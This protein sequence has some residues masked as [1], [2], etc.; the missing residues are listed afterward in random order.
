MKKVIGQWRRR[1]TSANERRSHSSPP[2]RHG[3]EGN[4][5]Q[6]NDHGHDQTNAEPTG[7]RRHGAEGNA[8]QMNDHD[9]PD[10]E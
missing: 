2:A 10:D 4:A 7:E 1:F 3:A 9:Q 6:M 8:L 5:L